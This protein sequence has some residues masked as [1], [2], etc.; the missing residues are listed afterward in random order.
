MLRATWALSAGLLI[1][2]WLAGPAAADPFTNGLAAANAHDYTSALQIWRPLAQEGSA[3]AQNALGVLY[4]NGM[5]VQRDHAAA[6][7]WFFKAAQQGLASG[8]YDLGVCYDHGSGVA[9][10]ETIA[11]YWYR[12]AA[13]QGAPAAQLTLGSMYAA[14]RGLPKDPVQAYVWLTLATARFGPAS[15]E[16]QTAANASEQVAATMTPDQMAQAQRLVSEWQPK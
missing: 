4:D 13:D 15:P 3:D 14:G 8:E 7:E 16:H 11:A 12:R 6:A 2:T 5:G 1:A 9:K 10:S